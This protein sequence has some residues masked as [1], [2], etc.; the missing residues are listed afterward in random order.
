MHVAILIAVIVVK[1][2]AA[3][4]ILAVIAALLVAA[5]IGAGAR[6]IPPVA[7]P[8]QPDPEA[9]EFEAYLRATRRPS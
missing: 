4:Y 8:R 3:W 2:I 5:F 7:P 1:V 9:A 6:E